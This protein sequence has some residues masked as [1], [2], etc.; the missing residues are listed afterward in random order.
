[1]SDMYHSH[2]PSSRCMDRLEDERLK[3]RVLIGCTGS[4]ATIKV[5][6]LVTKLIQRGADVRLVVTERSKHFLKEAELPSDCQ[7]LSDTVEWA[8]WQGRGDPVLHIDLV[9]W[10][11]IFLIAPLD[12]NTLG[13]MASGICDNILTCVARAWD[14]SKPLLFCPAMN[15]RMWEHPITETQVKQ[16][17]SWGYKEVSCISKKLMCGDTGIGGMA[18]V[19]SIVQITL[20]TLHQNYNPIAYTPHGLN[21]DI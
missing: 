9:K 4:V 1:M 17:K 19:D 13:K 7:V 10:A 3:K 15:T 21:L 14:T 16:L 18:E 6:Q 11:D 20:R 8:A 5:P 2:R 12:A